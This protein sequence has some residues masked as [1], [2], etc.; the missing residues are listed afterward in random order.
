VTGGM[1]QTLRVT[2]QTMGTCI[3][4]GLLVGIL[5]AGIPAWKAARRRVVDALR[6]VD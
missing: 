3:A 1:F 5:S 4:V 6:E 2:P